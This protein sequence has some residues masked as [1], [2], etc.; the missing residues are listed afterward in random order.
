MFTPAAANFFVHDAKRFGG[1]GVLKAVENVEKVI[2]PAI[3]GLDAM[4][5]VF[6]DNAMI[7]MGRNLA[8]RLKPLVRG[9]GH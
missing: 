7:E 6:I 1:K 4:N 5:Q 3:T 8:A 9:A 2:G